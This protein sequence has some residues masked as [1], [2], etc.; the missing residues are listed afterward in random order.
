MQSGKERGSFLNKIPG[1]SLH[2]GEVTGLGID[3]LNKQL[4]S[5]SLDCTIKLWDFFR[6]ELIKTFHCD[7][8]IENLVYNRVNDLIAFSQ[9]DI[10]LTIMNAKTGLKKVREFK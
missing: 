5:S 2:L 1:E 6:K 7:Y 10:S 4:I 8:P 3:T 9:S